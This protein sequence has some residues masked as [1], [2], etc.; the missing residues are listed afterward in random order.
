MF[1]D[2]KLS[3]KIISGFAIVLLLTALVGYAGFSSLGSVV[4]IVETVREANHLIQCANDC[5]QEE[6]D[7]MLTR[8]E[9]F[10]EANNETMKEIHN[11]IEV[12][13]AEVSNPA[14]ETL[15]QEITGNANSYK[16]SFDNWVRLSHEQENQ[17]TSMVKNANLFL[18]ACEKLQKEQTAQVENALHLLNEVSGASRAHLN[19]V[20]GVKDFLADPSLEKLTVQ[21][22]GTKCGFGLWLASDK[23]KQQ[24]ETA[25]PKFQAIV[26][27]MRNDHLTLH[28]TAIDIENARKKG[29]GAAKK[30]YEEKTA[31]ILKKILGMFSELETEAN[32]VYNTRLAA[33]DKTNE[34]IQYALQCRTQEKDF[35]LQGDKKYQEENNRTMQ[36]IYAKCDQLTKLCEAEKDKRAI[37]SIEEAAKEY[38]IA[39][40]GWISLWQE[41]QNNSKVM[42]QAAGKFVDNCKSF[43][44]N[45]Q[46]TMRSTIASSNGIIIGGALVAIVAGTILALVL[47]CG[48]TKPINKIISRLSLG[49]DQTTSS[50]GQ[51][52]S[53]SQS[54]AQG[55]SE[56]AAS[57]E[58]TTASMEEM[59]SMTNQNADNAAQAKKLA[60]TAWNNAETGTEAMNR[61]SMAIDD[62]KKSSDETAKII[63]TIDEIAFQTNLLA[64]NAA[65]EAAR[66]GEAGKGFAVVAEEVRNL[67]QRS[68]EAARSTS[69]MIA[70]SVK[71]ADNGVAI[72]KEVAE[73]LSEIAEGSRKVNDLIGE[74]AAASNEQ[75]QGIEQ[76]NTAISQMDQ[77]TQS[78]AASAEES[79]SA[80][81]ELSAQAEEL[82]GMVQELQ[83]IIGG[84][85]RF[86]NSS[87]DSQTKAT[88]PSKRYRIKPSFGP[89]SAPKAT[90]QPK[91]Q[92]MTQMPEELIPLGDEM[93]L[94]NF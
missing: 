54:L 86:N 51:V 27:R 18:V 53:S 32:R 68:A 85:S 2:L 77:V 1:K 22:D 79:A 80:S 52:S 82:N 12:L 87:N 29:D 21:K 84:C 25:G 40:D 28:A 66:A 14:G 49:A 26:N 20:L 3:T 61:M 44:T 9:K 10:Q 72:S 23:F 33:A 78:N 19:W 8:D 57:L 83:A 38:K 11:Q 41:Q 89:S 75:S 62:I 13:R 4:S 94:A 17:E 42:A 39:F 48:I 93:E 30:A 15:L 37:N 5:R 56:Q 91:S 58:E 35:M 90:S 67:A 6:K 24:A 81:E 69:G 16:D 55:A 34:L 71:N 76:I 45:E 88:K 59:A 31:P 73:A 46:E 43:R 47:T 70:D 65:V 60:E 7:F 64:L 50:A 92:S 63:K 74:I 36:E